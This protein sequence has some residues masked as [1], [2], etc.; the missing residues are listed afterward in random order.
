MRRILLLLITA[1]LI[2]G[3]LHATATVGVYFDGPGVIYEWPTPMLAF[4]AYL[5][6]HQANVMVSAIEYY[7]ITPDDPTHTCMNMMGDP[8]LLEGS[9]SLGH[10][11]DPTMGHHVTFWPPLNGTIPG[12]NLLCTYSLMTLCDCE[13]MQNYEI[14]VVENPLSGELRG[15]YYP[16]QEYFPIVGLTSVLCPVIA[17]QQESW[18]AIKSL[19]K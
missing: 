7:L 17:A 16:D 15:T 8:S 10:P 3:L 2:P 1:L 4:P 12:Y 18:G 6:I 5:Y 13:D 14:V 19:Y 11:F 9:T